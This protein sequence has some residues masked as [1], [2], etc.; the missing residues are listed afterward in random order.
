MTKAE[1]E[2]ILQTAFAQCEAEQCPLSEPQKQ[3]LRGIVDAIAQLQQSGEM[4]TDQGDNPLDEL[5]AEQRHVLLQFVQAQ[6]QQNRVWKVQLLNDW[7]HNRDS[8]EVQ[9]IRDE[10]GLSWLERVQPTHLAVYAEQENTILQVKL[11]DR[12]EV[13]N[14]LWEW[15]QESGP[16]APEWFPCTVI[17][18]VEKTDSGQPSTSCLIRFDNGMEYEVQGIYRWNR[19]NWRWPK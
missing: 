8:A 9:F 7:L 17:G 10:Y 16:C 1:I 3:I 6:E 11:G 19:Y 5:T 2:A 15:V 12:I 4:A 18:I 14:S 13:C